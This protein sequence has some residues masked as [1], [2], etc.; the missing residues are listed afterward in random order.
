MYNLAS[1][2]VDVDTDGA[3]TLTRSH[4]EAALRGDPH[5][6]GIQPGRLRDGFERLTEREEL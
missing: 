3:L 4:N 1:S 2:D 5:S 6:S